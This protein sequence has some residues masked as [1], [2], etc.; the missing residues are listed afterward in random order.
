ML[1]LILLPMKK[2]KRKN[3]S[4]IINKIFLMFIIMKIIKRVVEFIKIIVKIVITK[5]LKKYKIK[6]E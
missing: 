4:M 6:T 3:K 2:W 1:I 5:L